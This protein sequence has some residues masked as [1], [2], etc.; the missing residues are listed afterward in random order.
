MANDSRSDFHKRLAAIDGKAKPQVRARRSDRMGVYDHEEEKRRQR[1]KFPWKRV[2]AFVILAVV[3]LIF[4]KTL[5]VRDMGEEEY[6]S[7]LEQLR[8]GE[9]WE[10]YGAIIISRDP[11]MMVFE[12][13]LFGDKEAEDQI[14][15]SKT[16]SA[17][18]TNPEA[19]ESSN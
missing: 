15:G 17:P 11:L 10:P 13:A 9:G 14:D 18:E 16:I 5:V 8:N 6:Q 2:V 4:V 7:R 1:A 19:S 12:R 3:G